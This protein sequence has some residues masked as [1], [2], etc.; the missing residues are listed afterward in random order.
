MEIK[1]KK[2]VLPNF[3]GRRMEDNE[4]KDLRFNSPRKVSW[5]FSHGEKKAANFSQN[6]LSQENFLRKENKVVKGN[7][8]I[9]VTSTEKMADQIIKFT[10]FLTVAL[11]PLFFLPNVPSPLELGKQV[12]LILLVGIGCLAWVGKMALKSEIRVRRNFF[13]FPL[14]IFLV[15]I[16]LSSIFSV[17]P[18]QSFWG[19]FG[20]EG[21]SFITNLFLGLLFLLIVNNFNS[22]KEIRNLI[23]FFWGSGLVTA[24]IALLQIL[25]IFTFPFAVTKTVTFNTVGNIYLF[26]IFAGAML[27]LSLMLS[28]SDEIESKA[29]KIVIMVSSFFFFFLLTVVNF[30]ILWFVVLLVIALILGLSIVQSFN[31]KE[32]QG[33]RILPMVF[34][35]FSLIIIWKKE[36][37]LK[38]NNQIQIFPSYKT[39]LVMLKNSL[40]ENL[41][42]GV[43]PA[44]FDY[45][46]KQNRDVNSLGEFWSVVF[47]DS[48]SYFLTIA[49]TTG[50]LG[51]LG[52]LFLIVVGS[53]YFFKSII[54]SKS[55]SQSNP[56]S[57]PKN[58]FL[59]S[60]VGVA[61]FFITITIFIYSST[62]TILMVWWFLTV[63]MVSLLISSG[64][65]ES[66]EFTTT[67]DS[68]VS[69]LILSFSFV[70]LI[71]GL[72]S[73]L[74]LQTQ[75]YVAAAK[76]NQA[77]ISDSKGE[78]IEK[79][80]ENIEKAITFDSGRDVYFRNL[81]VALFVEANKRVLDK[82]QENLSDDDI[83]FIRA[84][85]S[86]SIQAVENAK[87]L[88]PFN[89]I[90]YI[91]AAQIYESLITVIPE[92]KEL[93]SQNYIKA[94]ELDPHNPAI[95]YALA[96]AYVSIVDLETK[97]QRKEET[98]FSELSQTTKDYINKAKDEIQKSL[99]I[100]PNYLASNILLASVY[101]LEGNLKKA[102]EK[103]LETKEKLPNNQLVAFRLG[104]FYYK[105]GQKDKAKNEFE[106]AVRLDKNYSNARYFL[107]LIQSEQGEKDKALENFKK[108]S[109]LNPDNEEVKKIIENLNNN[110]S[111]L[112]GIAENSSLQN[113]PNV[114]I[115]PENQPGINPEVEQQQIPQ[116]AAPEVTP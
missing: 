16:G 112:E 85:I 64:K 33:G 3:L 17:Y 110:R 12:F 98:V 63:V 30:K 105:D 72:V 32:G 75:K 47:D 106:E 5:G 45:I 76:F 74:Y 83:N 77:L 6:N 93:V 23:L 51:I 8:T 101:E 48:A 36:P 61:W 4:N 89:S 41:L 99:E 29:L 1:K 46:Y 114:P 102:I 27:V 80:R 13:L 38:L 20:G 70:I 22:I 81:A 56:S 54:S 11:L 35:V 55:V 42:L 44:H 113:A 67:S 24:I 91:S 39:S 84:K 62:T 109:E 28:M 116:E 21:K 18:N 103:E 52:F 115:S 69:S 57:E 65:I 50:L 19:Y 68:P 66:K 58:G 31:K 90:N 40:G 107:G 86:G 79:T 95:H 34:L 9:K 94:A 10:V 2:E 87:K 104:L 111:A 59:L 14:V 53:Y 15:I 7:E 82:K 108:I 37:I 88:N 92:A 97:N 60:G 71:I 49:S 78:P 26:G 100:M 96:R 73:V 43:G 25:G